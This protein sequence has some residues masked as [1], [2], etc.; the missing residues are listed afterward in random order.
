MRKV[1]RSGASS[2]A[3]RARLSGLGT[4]ERERLLLEVVR[5]QVAGVLGHATAHAIEADRA[6]KELG[7][8]SL[9]S[10]E[11]RNRLN[12]SA[13]LRLPATLVF[14]YP[15]A[16]AVA[17]YLDAELSESGAS[18][19]AGDVVVRQAIADD[20]PI[21]IVGMACRY[22]GGAESPE[23]L[24]DL[25][26]EGRDAV[27]PFPTDRG[28]DTGRLYD[29][30]PGTP[31]KS[32]TRMGGFLH[33]AARFDADFFGISPRE[34]YEMDPQQR[35][36]LEVSWEAIERA[37]IVPSTLAGSRTNVY[38]G[39]MYHDYSAGAN[40]GS[41]V[42]GRIA[43][44]LGLEGSAVTVDTACS[45]SLV[46]LHSAVQS[47][48][49]G[50]CDL[51]LVGGVAVM[52]TPE[53]FVEFSRQRGLAADG[54]AKSF[55]A[56]ADGTAWGEGAGM[57]LVERLSDARRL[58]HS[59]VAVVRGSALNQDGAS[60]GLTAPNG[61]SQV[62]VIRQA[63][64]N[65]GLATGDVDLVEAH[66]TGTTLGDPIE[67]QA[68]LATYG[69]G[70]AEGRPLWLGSVKS[71][72][73]H[74]QAAAGVA[75]IIKVVHA[76]RHGV[77]P[78][79]LHVDRPSDQVDWSA[80][81]VE[82]LTEAREWPETDGPRR[83]AVSSFGIS[84]TNAHVIIEQ[85]PD[86][87]PAQGERSEELPVQAWVLSAAGEDALKAQAARLLDRVAGSDLR[88]VDVGFSLVTSRAVLDQR[89]VVVGRD[90]DELL[91]ALGVLAEGREGSGV[92]RGTSRSAGALAVLFTGQGAQRV[93][94]GRELHASY[95]VFAEAFDA[96]VA[97]LDVHLS[98][99]LRDVVWGE[100]AEVLSRTELTQPALF[101]FETA[102]FRLLES[103]GV[104]PD[105]L[106]GHSVGELTAAHVSGVLSLA[107]AA[108]LVA[109]RARLMQA[110]PAGGAM[111]AIRASEDEVLPYLTSD[112]VSVAAV[113]G[114]DAV[115]I[116]GAEGEVLEVAARFEGEGRK[117][118][119]L[120]VSHAFHSPLMEPMLAE[121]RTVAESVEYGEARIP[122]VS[123]LTGEVAG[124][125][126]LR[127]AE[128]WV[129]HVREAV[130]F[131]DGI[132]AL[133]AAG[134]TVFLEA[135]PDAVLTAMAQDSAA[136]AVFVPAL[137]RKQSEP[138]AL[139][140]ALARL[141]TVGHA[142]DWAAFY[143]PT[144]ARRVDLP[145][146]AFQRE[147]YWSIPAVTDGD[148]ESLGLASADHP[149]LG[150]AVGL[151]DG[152]VVF[153][154][155]LSLTAQ[156]WIADHNILGSVL[157][158]GTGLVELA[159][160]AGE[161]VGC[162]LL[163]ELTLQ[164]PLVL[165]ESVGLQVQVAV[166]AAGD[167]GAR[168]VRV[169]SRAEDDREAPWTQHAEGILLPQAPAP[170][171]DLTVWPPQ[172]A[173]PVSVD[174]AY[175]RLADQGYG[176]GPVFQ[177]LKTVWQRG[178]EIFAE[179]TLPEEARADAGR[180]G[181]HPALLDASLHAVLL[182]GSSES[183][184]EEG[185]EDN[186]RTM[187]PFSW[188]GVALHAVGAADLR[189]RLVQQGSVSL[190]EVADGEGGPVLSV[191]ALAARAVDPDQL[192]GT[193]AD[194]VDPLHHLDWTAE[195]AVPT[196]APSLTSWADVV[197][198]QAVAVDAD[199]P[200]VLVYTCP[201]N[202]VGEGQ[203][204]STRAL[205]AAAHEVTAGVLEVLQRWLTDERLA[206]A[207]L[208]I[209]TRGAVSVE[210]EEVTDVAASAVW[211]LVR[212]AQAENPG[213]IVL[214]D[215]EGPADGSG[216][217]ESADELPGAVQFALASG[218]SEVALR[219]ARIRVPRLVRTVSEAGSSGDAGSA[220]FGDGTVLVTGGTG[221]LG[222]VVARH[223]VAVHQ[224]RH[225]ALVSRRGTDAPGATEL[226]AELEAA[227]AQVTVAACDVS[228]REALAAL[229]KE[230]DAEQPLTAVVH[231]AGLLDDGVVT[232]LTPE[233]L[234][235][236]FAPKADAAWHLHELTAGLNLSAFVMFSSVAGALGNPGQANYAAANAFLDGLAA[237][238]HAHGMPA[239]SIAWGLWEQDSAMTGHLAADDTSRLGV[240]ALPAEA[241][242][243]LLDAAVSSG[244]P[245][246]VAARLDLPALRRRRDT[247]SHVFHSLVG[248]P[249]RRAEAA[250]G[251]RQEA[252]GD[253]LR[254]RLAGADAEARRQELLALVR[255]QVAKVLGHER[256]EAVDVN[257]G[258][259]DAGID[260]LMA[261]E[262]R[263]GIGALLGRRLPAT[264]V[265]DYPSVTAVVGYM[266]DE[267]FGGEAE[268]GTDLLEAEIR[269]LE[270]MMAQVAADESDRARIA[271]LL[272]G[273][274]AGWSDNSADG[275]A[276]EEGEVDLDSVTADELFG[277]L[278][279]ELD[280]RN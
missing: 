116:S 132:R 252:S 7:F 160:R 91:S 179:V 265:F 208:V 209:A 250:S 1:A 64:A 87:E 192:R 190:I 93:G 234:S 5:E 171:F 100:D 109:A 249:P 31:G 30:E 117:T 188:S 17:S 172:D 65:A 222:A 84:G 241:G 134:V 99:P 72:M 169:H 47:L 224:V 103:W 173:E 66:G 251:T 150:A 271:D 114:P 268:N 170:D 81:A 277:I 83:A 10:V 146:Y 244:A 275:T 270:S 138:E 15:S 201:A 262:L 242:L 175:E 279:S 88:P 220:P 272:R 139:V 41:L 212:A 162:G 231:A 210:G 247:L 37:G 221:G 161:E 21:V 255:S 97:E 157:V 236:V 248:T 71:N 225:L 227:G 254:R 56:G 197:D 96:V 101:A 211:G 11:L 68:L 165:P 237:H 256:S 195:F 67:A 34:A 23:G 243:A 133:S 3:L 153:T 73:G 75:G 196:A 207:R 115:V 39:V 276:S 187:L 229:L 107:D 177:G 140:T 144:G 50:D 78:K 176:Y 213:R 218:E 260:S 106:A 51:A 180:F 13:G 129:R 181:F 152:G 22:P 164:S 49:S 126:D 60:N 43:Y 206:D 61:P 38:A 240:A 266:L 149:V 191:Q 280:A 223:L 269:K 35:L 54:R 156:P 202:P 94:M 239:Q 259:M 59:V 36:L 90:R 53:T 123:N 261:L 121:F 24:W 253:E 44:T 194:G 18:Q 166:G 246:L 70:R 178:E 204:E 184:D 69:Q 63:L 155:R 124:S 104:R 205:P 86:E 193:D 25:V 105:F 198:D 186:G 46:A 245:Q 127:S 131:G 118:S 48:R 112:A 58:G 122:V 143:A 159:L 148:P 145:T 42:S 55:A 79:T 258:F 6:F 26:A 183:N 62:R 228:D 89:A 219:G 135:G 40:E 4:E 82:L 74:T 119:R 92:V 9:T 85:A 214:A 125:E 8:D 233:R 52:A 273:I 130:R 20:D 80:G 16:R 185:A 27:S 189:V 45:S 257:R 102:L 163:E 57:L 113:N 137:R 216:D 141:H 263:N 111:V 32:Y 147:H 278:D 136:D 168:V 217:S 167:D 200:E 95:P 2:G 182:T 142:P 120:R 108:R 226:A 128:Y 76:M 29:P 77:L 98:T 12:A 33:D 235:R 154:G 151:P 238:R 199:V 203:G 274:A 19:A 158:P 28:W 215:L 174:G 267:L 230:F 110:L 232:G 264:F 14:D